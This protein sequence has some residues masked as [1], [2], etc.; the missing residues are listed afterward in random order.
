MADR[1]F[2]LDRRELMA[3]MGATA[4]APALPGIAAAEGRRSLRLT[5]E[6]GLM[7]LRPGQPDT[8]IWALAGLGA[9]TGSGEAT[10]SRSS[11]RTNLP[12]PMVMNWVGLD[13][14]PAA[15]P[16]AARP[17]LAPGTA[18]NLVIPLRHAGTLLCDIRLLGDGGARPSAGAGA[19]RGESGRSRS[20][21]TRSS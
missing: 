18:E 1:N 8:P 3:G 13:G 11:S 17:P 4:L 12:V 15:E 10:K 6:A 7:A 14:V 9:P 20:I 16:L 5:A 19:D 21:A 2:R